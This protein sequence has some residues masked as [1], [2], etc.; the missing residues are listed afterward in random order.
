MEE[1]HQFGP[2]QFYE[3]IEHGSQSTND[4]K[5][6]SYEVANDNWFRLIL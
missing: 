3:K 4:D 5:E 2:F 6:N 1:P